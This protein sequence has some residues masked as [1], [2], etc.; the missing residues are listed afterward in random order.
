[1]GGRMQETRNGEPEAP[2]GH[3]QWVTYPRSW[4]MVVFVNPFLPYVFDPVR[5][6]PWITPNRLTCISFACGAVAAGLVLLDSRPAYVMAGILASLS[7]FIDCMDGMVARM[8]KASSPFG[9][10]LDNVLDRFKTVLLTWAL[11]WVA[12]AHHEDV[13]IALLLVIN[14]S[15]F[16]WTITMTFE[17]RDLVRN[18]TGRESKITIAGPKKGDVLGSWVVSHGGLVG[19][20][21]HFCYRRGI[22]PTLTEV[23]ADLVLFSIGPILVGFIGWSALLPCLV[24][25]LFIYLFCL[26]LGYLYF[27]LRFFKTPVE[28]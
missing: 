11:I 28:P 3:S 7:Y 6:L 13:I 19:K 25:S 18:R 27:F 10:L 4:W 12:L 24:A 2:P 23:E 22:K 21:I 15:L 5:K 8:T 9:A 16:F 14:H 17:I 20:W 1:M 26:Q